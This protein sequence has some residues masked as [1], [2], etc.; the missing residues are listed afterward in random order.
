MNKTH[1]GSMQQ[2]TTNRGACGSFV[3]KLALDTMCSTSEIP[4]FYSQ[5]DGSIGIGS[6]FA[7]RAGKGIAVHCAMTG[8]LLRRRWGFAN[9]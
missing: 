9:E 8:A 5:F 3:R 7:R 4:F 6:F 2:P 1:S